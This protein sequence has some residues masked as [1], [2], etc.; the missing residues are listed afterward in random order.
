MIYIVEDVCEM[1]IGHAFGLFVLTRYDLTKKYDLNFFTDLI[2]KI[3]KN[4]IGPWGGGGAGG[5][6]KSNLHPAWLD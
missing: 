4:S 3:F 2:V 5:V 6:K 1:V